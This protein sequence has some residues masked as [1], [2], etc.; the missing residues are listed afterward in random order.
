MYIQKY[1]YI[2]NTTVYL[3]TLYIHMHTYMYVNTLGHI[4][5][6]GIFLMKTFWL[7]VH[8]IKSVR[9]TISNTTHSTLYFSCILIGRWVVPI[10]TYIW[11]AYT[12]GLKRKT[13]H[14]YNFMYLYH[15]Y[16]TT[17]TAQRNHI[18]E[19]FCSLVQ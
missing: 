18:N 1:V 12:Y 13:Y 16:T 3:R 6:D 2:K 8:I 5:A 19:T 11:G 7:F 9:F 4:L 14:L 15:P 10:P 17:P